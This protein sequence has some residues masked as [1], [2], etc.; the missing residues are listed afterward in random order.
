MARRFPQPR[1][2]SLFLAF[3]A[4]FAAS[5]CAMKRNAPA[6]FLS[7][8]SRL[9]ALP[10]QEGRMAFRDPEAEMS[11]YSRIMVD[12]ALVYYHPKVKSGK[13]QTDDLKDLIGYLH[14]ATVLALQEA[15]PI[16][17]DPG[18]GVLR[19]RLALTNVRP[20][21]PILKVIPPAPAKVPIDLR[22]VSIETELQDS[23]TGEPLAAFVERRIGRRLKWRQTYNKWNFAKESFQRWAEFLRERLDEELGG[24]KKVTAE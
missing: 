15:Y 16:V 20:A 7:D 23:L 4:A 8:Y 3:A 19:V 5:A 11:R 2:L 1:R 18:P 22:V 14:L 13:T 6:G 9:R 17:G 24:K 12:P 10:G 21:K